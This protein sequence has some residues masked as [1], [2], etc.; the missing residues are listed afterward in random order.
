[1]NMNVCSWCPFAVKTKS[2]KLGSRH[3]SLCHLIIKVNNHKTHV[4]LDFLVIGHVLINSF[5]LVMDEY[6]VGYWL[7]RKHLP[8][9]KLFSR[10]D[11]IEMA[12]CEQM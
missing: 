7:R 9:W 3:H 4:G 5:Q 11:C 12:L 10:L 8:A 6:C 1:M 2:L